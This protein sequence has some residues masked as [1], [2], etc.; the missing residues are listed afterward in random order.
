MAAGSAVGPDALPAAGASAPGPGGQTVGGELVQFAVV[1]VWLSQQQQPQ[2]GG[3]QTRDWFCIS[4]S[5][6]LLQLPVWRT[7]PVLN[8]LAFLE[9]LY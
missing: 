1:P 2:R 8:S 4:Q 7:V 3:L 5:E 9:N 6:W